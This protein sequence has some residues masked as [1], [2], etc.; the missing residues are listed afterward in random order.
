MISTYPFPSSEIHHTL[1]YRSK[2]LRPVLTADLVGFHAYDYA[3][4]LVSACTRNIGLEG[5][6][7]GAEDQERVTSVASFPI[8]I[9]PKRFIYDFKV[10]SR[11]N[12]RIDR[13]IFW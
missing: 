2:L 11:T 6:P 7:E 1:P 13:K 8:G 9:D 10:L 3:R 5:I 12:K 4:H